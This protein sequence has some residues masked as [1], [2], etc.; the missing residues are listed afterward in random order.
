MEKMTIMDGRVHI[1]K[2]PGSRFWQCATFLSGRNWRESTKQETAGLAK[3][4]AEDWYLNLRGKSRAGILKEGKTFKVVAKQF[5][6][7]YQ[8]LTEGQRSPKWVDQVEETLTRHLIPYF[9]DMLV[10]EITAGKVQEYRIHRAENG[11][12]GKPPARNTIANELIPL[13]QVL[14]TAKRHGWL[15]HVPDISPPFRGSVKVSHR[16]WFSQDEYRRLYEATR[17]RANNPKKEVWRWECEQL[18][19][20]VLFM[21]NTGLRPDEA[22]RLEYRDV[23]IVRDRASS[24]T[25][26]EIEVRGKRGKGHCKST[27]NAVR[28]YLRLQKRNKPQPTDRLFPQRHRELFR[29][30]LE[31][32]KMRRDRDGNLRSPYSLRHTYICMRLSEGADIYQV[33]KNCR[34]SVEM[35]QKHYAAHLKDTIDAAAVNVRRQRPSRVQAAKPSL[36]TA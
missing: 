15:E 14:K 6:R 34:T 30:I 21:A 17:E 10:S 23:K 36:V 35:I 9:G 1:Y 3:E 33:A 20:F 8:V 7:E 28:P 24:E 11:Y 4:F 29:A 26:L 12:R 32:L 13:R 2:R 5:L 27:S 19:D 16:A 31:E 25:I 22:Y 18:H